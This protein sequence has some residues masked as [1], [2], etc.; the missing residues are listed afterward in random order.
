M[1]N[2]R[3]DNV[4]NEAFQR[5]HTLE[6][7]KEAGQDPYPARCRLSH[8]IGELL[9]AGD[10]LLAAEE[11]VHTAGRLISFRSHGKT[12][13]AHLFSNGAKIQLYTR[14]DVL[15]ES[16]YASFKKLDIGDFVG[17]EGH[18]FRTKTG[19]LT[20][21]VEDYVLLAKSLRPL[22]EKWHGLRDVE[23]RYRQRY[24]DL[25][26]NSRVREV[27]S[28]RSR[29][30]H[31]LRLFFDRHRFLEVETPMMQPIPGGAAARPFVTYHNALSRELY[32]RIAPELYLKRLLVGGLERVYEINRNFRNEGLST[33]H[34]PE[35][36]MLEFYWAY[37]DYSRLMRFT[38]E[39]FCE[40][41][42][43]TLGRTE[44]EYKGR[45]ID[46]T[47]PWQT[48]SLTQ[49]LVKF[50]GFSE[51]ELQCHD[52][53]RHIAA[54]SGVDTQAKPGGILLKLFEKLVEPQLI[55]P[56][57][58]IDFPLDISPLAKS[59]P[60]A[61]DLVER[62]E[63]YIGGTE[64]ANAFTELNDPQE[65]RKRFLAQVKEREAGDQEAHR[66]DEDFLRAL[67]HGMPPAA[68]EGIG[69]DRLVMLFTDMPSIRDVILFPQLRGEATSP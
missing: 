59:K 69:I 9:E 26:A 58:I 1:E 41:A 53:L 51:G 6:A 17:V 50:G 5:L 44:L 8:S 46:L 57:F 47:P 22:P 68:G 49:S 36:T 48:F 2:T 37:T 27:F 38:E 63:L 42:S 66:L 45:R 20:I 35:F 13:F 56:T 10:D 25:I 33:E 3:D 55:Q 4:T 67:E 11:K 7:L 29:L 43:Q 54:K 18:L 24:L 21:W 32:L 28:L 64:I 31:A 39:L 14:R 65:Q 62:F 16:V 60:E 15:G 23:A 40:L 12:S 19:E 52:K 30:I 34:N 61:P